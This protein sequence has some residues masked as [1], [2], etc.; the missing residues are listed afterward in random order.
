MSKIIY[1]GQ[2][3][4][5][6]SLRNNGASE[7]GNLLNDLNGTTAN[8]AF[9]AEQAEIDRQFQSEENLKAWQR[10]M[11]ASNTSYQRA[12]ADIQKAGLNPALMYQSGISGANTPNIG[13][14]NGSRASASGNNGAAIISSAVQLAIGLKHTALGNA[15][16]QQ[17]M[18]LIQNNYYNKH[19]WHK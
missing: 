6:K 2:T 18:K 13:A 12:L 19:Y 15:A 14:P 10:E 1:P 16:G 11:E 4:I 7:I 3:N 8:N 5:L 9:N 17:A